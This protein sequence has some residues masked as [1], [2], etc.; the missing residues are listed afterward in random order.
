MSMIIISFHGGEFHASPGFQT[1]LQGFRKEKKYNMTNTMQPTNKIVIR[2]MLR[3]NP[4]AVLERIATDADLALA[5]VIELLPE[6]MWKRIDGDHFVDIMQSLSALGKVTLVMNTP[7]A[8]MEFS[9]ELPNGKLSH[10]FYNFAYNSPLHGHLRASH[11]QSIYLV[12]RP[13]MKRQTVS[14]QFINVS[15]NAMFKVF[16][17]RD[18]KGELVPEQVDAMRSWFFSGRTGVAV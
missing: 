10:G 18:E 11:C 1:T 17:G 6:S 8:I 4:G 3:E 16:A 12:E 2:E 5:E 13:F 9:G 15:G 7:D 14:L